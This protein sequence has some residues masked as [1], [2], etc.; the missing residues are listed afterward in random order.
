VLASCVGGLIGEAVPLTCA[1]AECPVAVTGKCL[2]SHSPVESCPNL[3]VSPS[4][5]PSP[6]EA[7]EQKANVNRTVYPGHELG[8]DQ[9]AEIM[10]AGYTHMIGV[11]GEAGTGKTCMLCSLYLLASCGE[12]APE[13]RFA[14]SLTLRGFESRLRDYRAWA[15]P[16]LPDRI[17]AHTELAHP[18]VPGF[19]HLAVRRGPKMPSVHDLLF[20]D[21]PGEWTSSLIKNT[22]SLE[23]L[24]FLRRADALVIAFRADQLGDARTRH[25]QLQ[26]ARVLFQRLRDSVEIGLNTPIVL[27]VTRCDLSNGKLPDAG[28]E[29]ASTAQDLNF[30]DVATIAVASFSSTEGVPSGLGI[31]NLLGT[32]LKPAIE[33]DDVE[34]RPRTERLFGQF[35]NQ[36]SAS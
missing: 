33:R 36:G 9:A 3:A 31:G 25:S 22:R 21:L 24:R 2:K 26:T 27:A 35:L 4:D 11:L 17:T 6:V 16:L 10:A 32:V 19:L 30:T 29:I 15:G 20:T 5:E 34:P 12:L 8:F 23:R 13:H 7:L 14:R 1:L 28:Y 18:R